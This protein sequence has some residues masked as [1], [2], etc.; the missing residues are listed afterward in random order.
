MTIRSTVTK[1]ATNVTQSLKQQSSSGNTLVSAISSVSKVDAHKF[2]PLKEVKG[3]APT[4][5]IPTVT[6]AGEDSCFI[7]ARGDCV[8]VAD[9]VGAMWSKK[10]V[11]GSAL[12][13]QLMNYCKSLYDSYQTDE[14]TI[15]PDVY[16]LLKREDRVHGGSSTFCC[17]VVRAVDGQYQLTS[18]VCVFF[19]V[20]YVVNCVLNRTLVILDLWC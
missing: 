3:K 20:D 9:G 11:D 1:V 13:T 12:P 5:S 16:D 17:A 19:S 6:T 14:N 8:G 18:W 7:S 15:L 2:S 4:W 10:G